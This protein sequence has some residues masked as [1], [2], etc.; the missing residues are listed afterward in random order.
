MTTLN[1]LIKDALLDIHAI[2]IHETMSAAT[3]QHALRTFNY[4]LDSFSVEGLIIH[5][6]TKEN[7]SFVAGTAS[8][9]IGSGG[10]FNTIRPTK[11]L[12]VYG[13]DGSSDYPIEII[14]EGRYRS[15]TLKTTSGTPEYMWANMSYPL[16]TLYFYPVPDATDTLYVHSEKSL[17]NITSLTTSISL[18]KGYEA[19]LKWNLGLW[20]CGSY[21]KEP[22]ALVATQAKLTKDAILRINAANKVEPI[23]PD[24]FWG[25]VNSS[26]TIYNY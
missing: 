3:A 20:L 19:M 8:Y 2:N 25:K 10:N 26:G 22:P 11:I 21:D 16:A 24:S 15:F 18:P 7:F 6:V 1:E 12:G 14:G 23:Q 4:M 13:N 9:T 5:A 17:T